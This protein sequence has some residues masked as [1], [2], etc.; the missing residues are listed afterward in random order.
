M[1][2]WKRLASGLLAT[3]PLLFASV[4]CF[5][6][7]IRA[8]E[9]LQTPPSSPDRGRVQVRDGSL[10]TDK[11]T[12][13][14]GVTFGVDVRPDFAFEPALFDELA[15]SAGL[16]TLHVNLENPTHPSGVHAEIA[17]A[18]VELTSR[19]GMYLVL[20][21]GGGNAGGTFDIDKAR[22]FW[23]FYAGR[24][25]ARTH[26]LYE[27]YNIPEG[28]CDAPW[29]PATLAMELE[30]HDL[31]RANAPQSHIMLLSY[32]DIPTPSALA[33]SL[34][35]LGSSID[36]SNAS[37]GFHSRGNCVTLTDL[38]AVLDVPRSRRIAPL[39]SEVHGDA[40]VSDTIL[41]EQ[42]QVGWFNFAWLVHDSDLNAFKELHTAA[43]VSWCPDFG[44]WP[45]AA[46]LCRAP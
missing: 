46:G 1:C 18:L 32:A 5:D 14:R 11:G 31:I 19:A 40:P 27:I 25:A 35:G 44:D 30:M 9:K 24:Y 13:L 3:G 22:S 39:I 10:L 6:N 7:E 15:N 43:G 16:N 29:Q 4:G 37:V 36:W 17:D 28:G 2:A 33:G 41:F 8:L 12:R 38:P 34:D 42:N 20:T 26:V 45:Q 23:S 21:I